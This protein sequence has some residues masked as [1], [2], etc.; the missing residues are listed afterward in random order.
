MS[1]LLSSSKASIL[2]SAVS[3]IFDLSGQTVA[4]G[5]S[6]TPWC[7]LYD[8]NAKQKILADLVAPGFIVVLMGFIVIFSKCIIRRDIEMMGKMVNLSSTMISI[9]LLIIGRILATLFQLI[10]CQSVGSDSVH[11]YF[12][13]EACYDW[14]FVV[15]LIIL[16]SITVL[17]GRFFVYGRK[18]TAPDLMDRRRFMF[19][20]VKRYQPRYWYVL[21]DC[22]C[23]KMTKQWRH[24]G[25]CNCLSF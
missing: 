4:R 8:L 21:C 13:Y 1:Q 6:F 2:L 22:V 7:F 19:E 17:F 16:L 3:G 25:H 20:L 18:L 15:A 11:F 23:T 14:T 5:V 12:G 24:Y 9:F 10:S